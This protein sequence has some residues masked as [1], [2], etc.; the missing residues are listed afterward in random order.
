MWTATA[1][2]AV[3]TVGSASIVSILSAI[4]NSKCINLSLC[5]G[6]IS[7]VRKVPDVEEVD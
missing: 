2:A 7:C 3:I 1:I 5:W 6:C 4:Q